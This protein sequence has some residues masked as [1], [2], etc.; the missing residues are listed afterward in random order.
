[1]YLL[2]ICIPILTYHVHVIQILSIW[3]RYRQIDSLDPWQIQCFLFQ[4]ADMDTRCLW[5]KDFQALVVD[6]ICKTYS[7]S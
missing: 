5:T 3:S 1:M 7:K 4:L 2:I 6:L